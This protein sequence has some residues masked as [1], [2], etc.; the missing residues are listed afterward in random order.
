MEAQNAND[1]GAS[2][3]GKH[4]LKKLGH[5]VMFADDDNYYEP[6]A[7]QYIRTT[8]QHDFDGL[9][10]FQMRHFDFS[11]RLI[12]DLGTNGEVEVNN[13]DTGGA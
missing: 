7:L 12:P 3:K 10:I 13:V 5:F 8:V 9:Y 4:Q 11:G 2:I 6:D 1:W